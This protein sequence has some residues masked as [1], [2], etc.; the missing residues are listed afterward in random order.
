MF[1]DQVTLSLEKGEVRVSE[2][3]RS[4]TVEIRKMGDSERP[5]S[6]RVFTESGSAEGI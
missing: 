5:V 4:V 6:V 1:I 3:S 2:E